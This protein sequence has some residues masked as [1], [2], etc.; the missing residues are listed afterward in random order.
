MVVPALYLVGAVF[1]WLDFARTNPD[2]LANIGIVLYTLPV[3][4]FG[5]FVLQQEFPFAPGGYYEAHAIYFSASVG[6]LALI[7]F[8][9]CLALEKLTRPRVPSSIPPRSAKGAQGTSK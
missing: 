6:L 5:I 8:A 1:V 9:A 4:L 3:A 2:G 7:L